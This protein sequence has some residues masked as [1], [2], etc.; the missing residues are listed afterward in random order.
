MSHSVNAQ[1]WA[2]A[3]SKNQHDGTAI[4]FRYVQTFEK[5][6]SF[7]T[8]PD[9]V[10]LV[11]RYVGENGM[12]SPQERN[13]MDELEDALENVIEKDGF[14][15]LVLVSTGDNLKEWTY[16]AK[17][18]QEFLERLNNAL[19]G[20]DPFPI[21]IHAGPDPKWSTYTRFISGVEK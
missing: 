13:R 6:F 9:R 20:K 16:Y 3:V 12:P 18:E 14:S 11:W 21:E 15:T 4:I 8:Q 7:D 19:R 5:D 2:T 17:S 10:I 1:E